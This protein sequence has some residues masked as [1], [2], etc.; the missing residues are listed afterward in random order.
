MRDWIEIVGGGSYSDEEPYRYEGERFTAVWNINSGG[1][2]SLVVTYDDCACGF[3]GALAE[4]SIR[5]PPS[6][7]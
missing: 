2:D 4:A 3:T 7:R 6:I 5:G 1:E